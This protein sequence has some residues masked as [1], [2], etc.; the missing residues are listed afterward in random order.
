MIIY[1]ADR[2]LNII[3]SASTSLPDGLTVTD[4]KKTEDVETGVSIFECKIHFEDGTRGDVKRSVEVGNYL[5][6]SNGKE[7]EFYQIIETEEDTKK[8]NIYAYAEDDGMDLLNEV[9]GPY[10]ADKAYNIAHYISKFASGSGFVIGVNEAS[11]LTRK[12]SWDG[13]ATAAE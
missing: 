4:D 10:K 2:Q 12:L 13:E 9:V 1:F 8:Q 6:R 5:L 11:T 3:G 7:N